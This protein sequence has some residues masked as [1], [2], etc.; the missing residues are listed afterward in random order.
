MPYSTTDEVRIAIV[1]VISS[2]EQK[3]T[4]LASLLL[5]FDGY[6]LEVPAYVM[7]SLLGMSRRAAYILTANY[8]QHCIYSYQRARLETMLSNAAE[9][10]Q[11]SATTHSGIHAAIMKLVDV[12]NTDKGEAY[13]DDVRVTAEIM[14]LTRLASTMAKLEDN[15]TDAAAATMDEEVEPVARPLSPQEASWLRGN[16]Q[17]VA[18]IT[19]AL[20]TALRNLADEKKNSIESRKRLALLQVKIK[21]ERS[22][23]V[24][25]A[26]MA[27]RL[28]LGIDRTEHTHDLSQPRNGAGGESSSSSVASI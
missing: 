5:W 8:L 23:A 22:Q 21:E 26:H 11:T 20:A 19:A 27:D 10:H 18:V 28:L 2:I 14:G 25:F 17:G 9:R 7:S 15:Y 3:E 1:T 16:L 6:S 4:V 12:T 24:A 13:D